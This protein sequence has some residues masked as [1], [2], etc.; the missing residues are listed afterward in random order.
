MKIICDTHIWYGIEAGNIIIDDGK[1]LVASFLNLTELVTT[2]KIEY[3]YDRI[4]RI[5]KRM[6]QSK[7]I[8]L[9]PL[10]PFA[11]IHFL[12]YKIL[13]EKNELV[14]SFEN[15]GNGLKITEEGKE[16]IL[17]FA[18]GIVLLKEKASKTV[19]SAAA[20]AKLK[21]KSLKHIR[22]QDLTP[23]IRQQTVKQV[24]DHFK[25]PVIELSTFNWKKLE[26]FIETYKT[27]TIKLAT[28]EYKAEVND[29]IDLYQLVYVQPGN[30][31]WT[32]ESKW[33]KIIIDA[34]VGHYLFE[35]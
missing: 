12:F 14:K 33:K 32:K 34:G 28:G 30:L 13:E 21:S 15:L 24:N 10:H 22:E 27:W 8:A 3:D 7:N 20:K 16:R 23:A 25:R 2:G 4:Q 17:E 19:N 5:S 18:K 1:E 31:Y 29:W 9:N 6:I 35:K 11:H 26:L